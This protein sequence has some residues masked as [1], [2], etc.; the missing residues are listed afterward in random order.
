MWDLQAGVNV[1]ESK[2]CEISKQVWM[3]LK[4]KDVRSPMQIRTWLNPPGCEIFY[5]GFRQVIGCQQGC[6]ESSEERKCTGVFNP[7]HPGPCVYHIWYKQWLHTWR[8]P[9]FLE[10]NVKRL[11]NQPPLKVCSIRW[12]TAHIQPSKIILKYDF[13]K[14]ASFWHNSRG[15]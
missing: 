15:K 9:I 12:C 8:G 10:I 4:V 13:K 7:K 1:A 14:C 6:G 2:G 3:W 11:S 5:P